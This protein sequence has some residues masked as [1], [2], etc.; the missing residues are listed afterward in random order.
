M[1]VRWLLFALFVRAVPLKNFFA[2]NNTLAV[3]GCYA[4]P[5]CSRD[6]A[7]IEQTVCPLTAPT[8]I[9]CNAAGDLTLLKFSDYLLV[10]TLSSDI[11]TYTM[12]TSVVLHGLIDDFDRFVGLFTRLTYLYAASFIRDSR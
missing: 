1:I 10:G 8:T 6:F 5:T 4:S 12:N 11:G 9:R 3:A 2:L 7:S